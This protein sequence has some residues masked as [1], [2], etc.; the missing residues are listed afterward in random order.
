M[1]YHRIVASRFTRS[2]LQEVSQMRCCDWRPTEYVID[3]GP[4]GHSAHKLQNTHQQVKTKI[5]ER[6]GEWSEMF[7]RD[8]DLGIMDQAYMKL[9]TQSMHE[10]RESAY[11]IV[12]D[13]VLR[14]TSSATVKTNEA[15]HHRHRPPEGRR[16]TTDGA[17]AL[18]QGQDIQQRPDLQLTNGSRRR[19]IPFPAHLLRH[20]RRHSL[21]CPSSLRLQAFRAR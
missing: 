6:M 16:R 9:K 7:R 11:W 19:T 14:S 2:W 15:R 4:L 21:P 13:Q 1:H 3:G 12:T 5:Y 8:P 18:T 17:C 20:N 10:P